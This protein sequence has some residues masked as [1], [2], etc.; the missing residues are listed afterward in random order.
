M[1]QPS[2]LIAALVL[3][4]LIPT[5]APAATPCTQANLTGNWDLVSAGNRC[6]AIIGGPGYA[7]SYARFSCFD[8]T[9]KPNTATGNIY[10]Q[11]NC[12]LLA[13]ITG[14]WSDGTPGTTIT[15]F[16]QV[17][18]DQTHNNIIGVITTDPNNPPALTLA[19]GTRTP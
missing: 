15:R 18:L 17:T 13:V 7:Q 4:A 10:V 6:T 3:T 11:S 5:T 1:F 16:A 8:P 14:T 12:R 9:G 19:V 2:K